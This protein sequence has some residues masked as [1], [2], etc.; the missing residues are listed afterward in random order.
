MFSMVESTKVHPQARRGRGAVS[1]ASGR[2]EATQRVAADDGW[3]AMDAEPPPLKTKVIRDSSRTVIATN[4]SPDIAFDQSINPYRGCEHGCIDCFARPTHA[5]LGLSP[6]LDFEST[7]LI[8]PDAP[9]LLERELRR[10]RYTCKVIAM[11]TNTDPYQ[12]LEKRLRITREILKVLDAFNHPVGIVTKSNLIVR[13][14][15][16]LGP[17]ARRGL[18]KVCVSVTTLDRALARRM[19]PRAPTPNR[20]LEAIKALRR[21]GVPTGVMAAPMVPA[22]NDP[23]L[24]NILEAAAEAGATEAG[25]ILL[26]LPL[27]IKDLWREWLEEHYPDRAARIM[28]HIRA[29]R[30]GKD[31]DAEWN[32]RMTGGGPYAAMIARRFKL[33]TNRLGLNAQRLKLDTSQFLPP[34]RQ[35]DQLSLL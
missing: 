18:A 12:P 28:S 27:E 9:A 2:F 31:Y 23:E 35:G 8:K 26:R 20:R 34:P 21:A 1:N 30:G 19:E 5:F 25:Y 13:D 3:G 16:I 6:G 22:L 11:G 4:Q 7:L 32:K 10:P 24:E 33:A 14:L 29:A 17:M 15:D